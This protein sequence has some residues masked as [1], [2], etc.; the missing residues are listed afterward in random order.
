MAFAIL[1]TAMVTSCVSNVLIT[2]LT[3]K[4]GNSIYNYL[5]KKN[6]NTIHIPID[7]FIQQIDIKEKI[8]ISKAF[9]ESISQKKIKFNHIVTS[10]QDVI[11]EVEA[12]LQLIED[13]KNKHKNKYFTSYRSLNIK[14]EQKKLI[15]YDKILSKRLDYLIKLISI[16]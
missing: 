3:S 16:S 4:A 1:S 12:L 14:K 11:I 6:E 13:K 8:I 9:V 7:E 15:T 10:L 2:K 5:F